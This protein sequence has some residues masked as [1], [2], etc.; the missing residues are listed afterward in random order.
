MEQEY[1]G[2]SSAYRKETIIRLPNGVKLFKRVYL[3][4]EGKTDL[5]AL[6]LPKD[7]HRKQAKREK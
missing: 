6:L 3:A 4:S 1:A 2:M 7:A 5:V